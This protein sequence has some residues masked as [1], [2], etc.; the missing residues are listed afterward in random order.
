MR[1]GVLLIIKYYIC[2]IHTLNMYKTSL[3]Q[4]IAIVVVLA[5]PAVLN[6]QVPVD[7]SSQ[8]II[9][10]G[11]V[12]YMHPVLKGQT[13]Y[14]ISRAYKV[15]IDEITRNNV[16]QPNGIQTEQIL[17]IP[18]SVALTASQPMPQAPPQAPPQAM[19][20]PQPQT[21]QQTATQYQTQPQTQQQT[22]TQSQSQTEAQ[23][24]AKTMEKK[25]IKTD[26]DETHKVKK[27]E[28]LSSI[29]RDHG[30]TERELKKANKGLLFPM[31]GMYLMI[32]AKQEEGEAVKKE[33]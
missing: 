8:K 5:L 13:L 32:P 2:T 9:S 22:A 4:K 15:T 11:K 18:S 30:I 12:Y 26:R 28:S 25:T 3:L 6:G 21:P 10:G 29:A 17:K 20:P 33:K 1:F 19:P 7:I 14:S 23:P 24:A 27:G 16:I 31:P